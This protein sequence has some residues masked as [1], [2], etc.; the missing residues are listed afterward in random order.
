MNRSETMKNQKNRKFYFRKSIFS[1]FYLVS[2]IF[3]IQICK[4]DPFVGEKIM[5]T[6]RGSRKKNRRFKKKCYMGTLLGIMSRI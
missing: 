4:M 1:C 5:K 3:S 6:S 2:N